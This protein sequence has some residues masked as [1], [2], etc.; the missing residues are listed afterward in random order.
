ME[1]VSCLVILPY[2]YGSVC[3]KLRGLDARKSPLLATTS[4]SRESRASSGAGRRNSGKPVPHPNKSSFDV[5]KANAIAMNTRADSTVDRRPLPAHSE[6]QRDDD[7]D[8]SE[9]GSRSRYACEDSESGTA[10]QNYTAGSL[11][12]GGK[13]S[14]YQDME[15]NSS[16]TNNPQHTVSTDTPPQAQPYAVSPVQISMST[17]NT[18]DTVG[19]AGTD[20]GASAAS[21]YRSRGNS[22]SHRC[23]VSPS[24]PFHVL[25]STKSHCAFHSVTAP[26]FTVLALRR[27]PRTGISSASFTTS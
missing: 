10:S 27:V 20:K 16:A 24:L 4:S 25:S 22:S 7:D 19:T 3:C 11:S 6:S 18:G 8:E 14:E 13:L 12:A 15:Y 23:I 5:A 1:W 17:Y 2:L 21:G 26:R 9:D